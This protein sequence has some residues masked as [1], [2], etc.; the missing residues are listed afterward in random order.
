MEQLSKADAI[1]FA[2]SKRYETAWLASSYSASVSVAEAQSE[3][4]GEIGSVR[5]GAQKTG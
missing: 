2:K 3:A 5:T 1:A 4:R